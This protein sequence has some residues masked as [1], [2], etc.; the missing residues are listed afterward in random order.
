M[1]CFRKPDGPS[2][3]IIRSTSGTL[4]VNQKSLPETKAARSSKVSPWTN[5]KSIFTIPVINPFSF[6]YLNIL[7]SQPL[8]V[9]HPLEGPAIPTV[10]GWLVDGVDI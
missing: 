7:R 9:N 8:F 5:R 1:S 4:A 6:L 3:I 10:P 2:D